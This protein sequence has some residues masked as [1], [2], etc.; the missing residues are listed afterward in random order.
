MFRIGPTSSTLSAALFGAAAFLGGCS[1]NVASGAADAEAQSSSA[2]LVVVERTVSG[3][4]PRAETV[5]RFV[6]VRSGAVDDGVM[7]LVGAA[8]ELPAVGTCARLG[9]ALGS[10]ADSVDGRR[11]VPV[12]LVD[13][14]PVYIEANGLPSRLPTR[15]LPDVADL[16]SGV[17][18]AG[19]ADPEALPPG[20]FYTLHVAGVRDGDIAGFDAAARAPAEIA[21]LR[22]S[23]EAPTGKPIRIDGASVDLRWDA[24]TASDV[25]YVDWSAQGGAARPAPLVR[26]VFADHGH[27]E[28]PVPLLPAATLVGDVGALTVHRLHREPFQAHGLDR[29]EVRFDFAR[30]VPFTRR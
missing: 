12:E 21:G 10:G 23:G 27:A 14:G 28:V 19:S 11:S 25:V 2:A 17:V 6:R 13:V 7:R 4:S 26:C 5:A 29:G 30:V 3:D 9:G 8:I 20:A 22:L 16:V 15:R 24:G 1:A 18:Y